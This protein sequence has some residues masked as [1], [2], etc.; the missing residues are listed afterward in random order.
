MRAGAFELRV[1]ASPLAVPRV[2]W[3]V[4]KYGHGSVERN[5]VKR[6]LREVVRLEWLP[7]L[8]PC[9]VVIRALPPAY[10]LDWDAVRRDLRK[11]LARLPGEFAARTAAEPAPPARGAP[12]DAAVSRGDGPGAFPPQG[13]AGADDVPDGGLPGTTTA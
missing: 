8:P 1:G 2:G 5:R 7:V 4:P 6:R 3:I 10:A 9:D 11:A 12:P 13:E